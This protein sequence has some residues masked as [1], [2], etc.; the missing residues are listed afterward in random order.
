MFLHK[1]LFA[2]NVQGIYDRKKY[3]FWIYLSNKKSTQDPTAFSSSRLNNLLIEVAHKLYQRGLFV[4]VDSAYGNTLFLVTSSEQGDIKS[5]DV[6]GMM[7]A[8][9]FYC[10]SDEIY[11]RCTFGEVL[12]RWEIMWQTL[13]FLL[14]KSAQVIGFNRHNGYGIF[15]E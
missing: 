8:F 4:A 15:T 9:I 5:T 10:S 12:M 7:D 6:G 3:F 11:I 13:H 14:I 1:R 2:I